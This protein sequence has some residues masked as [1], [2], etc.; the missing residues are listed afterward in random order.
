MDETNKKIIFTILLILIFVLY[1]VMLL[2]P[3]TVS[4]FFPEV[5]IYIYFMLVSLGVGYSSKLL[6]TKISDN[7]KI[8][9]AVSI[10]VSCILASIMGFFAVV[11]KMLEK[12]NMSFEKS[13]T[14]FDVM[15]GSNEM[16]TVVAN[17][18]ILFLLSFFAFN[19]FYWKNINEKKLYL[20][21]LIPLIVYVV[22]IIIITSIMG[23]VQTIV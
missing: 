19:L 15:G 10:F 8:Y 20:W 16:I 7:E 11:V 9:L 14:G 2:V 5:S 4:I 23:S 13:S 12:L 18:H 21:Y 22:L 1:V 3:P 17:P 6:L